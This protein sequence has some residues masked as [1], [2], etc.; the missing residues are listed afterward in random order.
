MKIMSFVI[1]ANRLFMLT[2]SRRLRNILDGKF[3][4]QVLSS[5]TTTPYCCDLSSETM[6]MAVDTALAEA[7]YHPANLD[8]ERAWFMEVLEEGLEVPDVVHENPTVHAELALIVAKAEGKINNV[9]PYIG[10][11]KPSC[12]MCSHYICAFNKVMKQKIATKGSRGKAY[13]GWFWPRLPSRDG[14]LRPAFLKLIR[15]QLISDFN[16]YAKSNRRRLSDSS[17]GSDFPELDIDPTEDSITALIE[18]WRRTAKQR[19]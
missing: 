11:S 16:D 12:I 9:E 1:S 4:V 14:E 5:P 2:Q 19:Q 17:V 7:G 10:V 15:E 13:T 8:E 18:T 3:T 6:Q